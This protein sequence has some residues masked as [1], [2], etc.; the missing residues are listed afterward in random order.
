[1]QS[2]KE[3]ASGLGPFRPWELDSRKPYNRDEE[4]HFICLDGQ[5]AVVIRQEIGREGL[6]MPSLREVG[7]LAS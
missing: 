5:T 2:V 1:M 4:L 6:P 7:S 3:R